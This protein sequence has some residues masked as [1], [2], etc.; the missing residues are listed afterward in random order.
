MSRITLLSSGTS[1][2]GLAEQISKRLSLPISRMILKQFS[3]FE[4]SVE[5]IES[6]RGMDVFILQCFSHE[7]LNQHLMELLIVI[8][9]CKIASASKS[10]LVPCQCG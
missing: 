8:S 3:N 6:V 7:S 4:T 1:D 9:A 2:A 5:I 10:K